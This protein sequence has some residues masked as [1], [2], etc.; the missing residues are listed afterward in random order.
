MSKLRLEQKRSSLG[1]PSELVATIT[2]LMHLQ[3]LIHCHKAQKK[4]CALWFHVTEHRGTCPTAVCFLK[5]PLFLPPVTLK[6]SDAPFSAFHSRRF[7]KN[8]AM[9]SL[10]VIVWLWNLG[11]QEQNAGRADCVT[12]WITASASKPIGLEGNGG[13]WSGPSKRLDLNF[14]EQFGWIEICIESTTKGRT[15]IERAF[16]IVTASGPSPVGFPQSTKD[17]PTTVRF[18]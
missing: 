4:R 5:S 3:R 6:Y 7:P 14:N 11:K 17:Q 15:Q 18:C 2:D 13:L 8:M 10:L 12:I 9:R 1:A 16:D